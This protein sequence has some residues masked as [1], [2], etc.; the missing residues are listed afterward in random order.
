MSIEVRVQVAL[1]FPGQGSQVVGM[2]RDVYTQS[3]AA[4]AV[5]ETANTVLGFDL[6]GLCFD[7]PNETLMATEYAQP[8][9]LTTSIALLALL[10][11]LSDE[12]GGPTF[13]AKR[14]ACVAGHSLGEYSALVAA[15]ALPFEAALRLVRRRGEL[16]ARADQG[17]MAAVL[18]MSAETLEAVCRDA[19][20]T[21]AQVVVANY[22]SNE[23][24]VISGDTVAVERA[25]ALAKEQGARRVVPLKVSAAFHSPLMQAAADGLWP[26]LETALISDPRT[27]VVANVTADVLRIANDIRSELAQQVTSPVRWIASVERMVAEGVTTFVEVGPGSVLTGL[28]KRI[29]PGKQ[30]VNI[31]DYPSAKAWVV[32]LAAS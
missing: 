4:R 24:L 11:E 13:V 15:G 2:G 9:I 30:L 27:P 3:S 16:M 12:P 8:A 19:S 14:A 25:M 20:Q 17:T 7:G 10:S 28:V 6:V 21:N 1:L 32:Q 22:N 29:A 31:H 18:G 26:D 5:F 23:Q